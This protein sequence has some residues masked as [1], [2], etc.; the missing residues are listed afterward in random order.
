MWEF[1]PAFRG[2]DSFLGYFT[3]GEDYFQ[4]KEWGG[5]D[6]REQSSSRCGQNCS[7]ARWDLAGHYSTQVFGAAAVDIIHRHAAAAQGS[8]PLHLYLP[9]QAVHAPPEA[10][11]SYVEPYLNHPLFR[12]E[13]GNSRAI[14][15]GML[16]CLDEALS[17]ITS[18]LADEAMWN[19]LDGDASSTI[20]ILSADNGAPT[21]ECGGA[22]GGQNWPLRGGSA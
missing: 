15:A 13:S 5:Y 17:N 2:F 3:G 1:T 8:Q 7:V 14:F 11:E 18:A 6:F 12:N 4:H 22:Q 10:P 20:F 19:E 16:A 9:F 21:P